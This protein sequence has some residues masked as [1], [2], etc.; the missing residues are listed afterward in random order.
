M[1]RGILTEIKASQMDRCSQEWITQTVGYA[2]L[3]G[4]KQIPVQKLRIVNIIAGCMWEW[5]PPPMDIHDAAT[6]MAK[7]WNWH[8]V[9]LGAFL[10]ACGI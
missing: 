7:K 1:D 4:V 10:R 9:E 2:L 5:T 8:E 6:K 3:L